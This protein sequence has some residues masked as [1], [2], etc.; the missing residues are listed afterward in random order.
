MLSYYLDIYAYTHNSTLFLTSNSEASIA[1]DRGNA[2]NPIR[3]K[4]WD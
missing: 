2:E 3:S 1:V 4:C